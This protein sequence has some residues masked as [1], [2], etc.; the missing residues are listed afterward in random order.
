MALSRSQYDAIMR[1]YEQQLSADREQLRARS[2]EVYGK[3]PELRAAAADAGAGALDAYRK[4]MAG[5]DGIAAY[6]EQR[7][8]AARR[9]GMLLKQAG[10]PED[11]LEMRYACPDCRDTGFIGTEKCHCF[12]EKERK[13]L[14]A[15]ARMDDILEKENFRTLRY[16]VYDDTEVIPQVGMTQREYMTRVAG[17]CRQFAED[18]PEKRGSLL[19]TGSTG[20]GKTFLMNCIADEL[21]RRYFS[22]ICLTAI[23]LFD[24]V[25]EVRIEKSED[26]GRRLLYDSIFSCDMLIIDDLG[27]ELSNSLTASSL[28]HILNSRLIEGRSLMISTNLGMNGLRDVYTERVTSRIRSS[29]EI[30]PLYGRDIRHM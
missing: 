20:T 24:V 5:E 22:V 29:F 8:A 26:M 13:L 12:R 1:E 30:L 23:E 27:S 28:F 7:E 14:Y 19:L 2:A 4:M 17:I 3:V 10:Y 18:F 21:L 11:Y 16:D 9:R 25:A 6:R 15:Q